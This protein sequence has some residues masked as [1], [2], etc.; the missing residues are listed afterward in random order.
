MLILDWSL[1]SSWRFSHTPVKRS[2]TLRTSNKPPEFRKKSQHNL[3]L[4]R[5]RPDLLVEVHSPLE[6][7]LALPEEAD[8]REELGRLRIWDLCTLS[9]G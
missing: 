4:L 6:A 7:Q 3:P 8:N 1:S 2:V 5:C 9:K